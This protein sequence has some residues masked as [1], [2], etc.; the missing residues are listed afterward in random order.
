MA[1]ATRSQE[2]KLAA[3][4][5]IGR[6]SAHFEL[7]SFANGQVRVPLA[8]GLGDDGGARLKDIGLEVVQLTL[9]QQ[10][11]HALGRDP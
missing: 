8:C 7:C 10:L 4:S 5:E 6:R 2:G 1:T 9:G 3:A 11:L